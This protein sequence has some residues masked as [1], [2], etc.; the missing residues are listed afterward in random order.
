MKSNKTTIL[1][2][3]RATGQL[4]IGNYLGALKQFI[5]LQNDTKNDCY[6]FIA[7]LHALTTP[8]EPKNLRQD[9]LVVVAEYLAAGLDPKKCALFL[10]SN[11]HE[12]AEL[13]WIFSCMIGL[14]EL[15]RM[16]QF[17][18]KSAAHKNN[19]NA[20]LLTYP[21]LMAADILLYKP[22]GVP[23]GEDQ[24]Q[25]LELARTIAR[26]FNHQFGQTFPEVKAYEKSPLRIMSLKDP[27]KKMSKTGGDGVMLSDD[28]ETITGKFKKAVTAT[29]TKNKSEGVDNLLLI[30]RH[31]GSKQQIQYFEDQVKDGTIKF[32][33]LKMTL[34]EVVS[35]HFA[36][37][38]EK[39]EKYLK[40]TDYLADVL[41]TGAKKA[42]AVAEQTLMEVKEKI[43]L[44]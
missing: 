6:F 2:G 39:R 25:H 22:H 38:R 42:K 34:A 15:E 10:Q 35:D 27:N 30:L 31:F 41:A 20:G 9:T 12:H 40:D 19:I 16:T 23:V 32:S 21:A 11:V 43:G 7:D 33:E 26:K 17:K 3:I 18:D 44:V 13:G 5:D 36:D 4:H 14:G 24:M 8:F 29:D 1:S 37:F 28:P